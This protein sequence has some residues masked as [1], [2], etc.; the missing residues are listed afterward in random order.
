MKI[1]FHQ[2]VS[3][4]KKIAFVPKHRFFSNFCSRHEGTVLTSLSYCSSKSSK[5]FFAW[6]PINY[7]FVVL[8]SLSKKFRQKAE[9]VSFNIPE[10]PKNTILLK[11]FL[12]VLFL[13][14]T[15]TFWEFCWKTLVKSQHFLAQCPKEMNRK[16]FCNIFLSEWS[17]RHVKCIFENLLE[18][19]RQKP[20][21]V[22]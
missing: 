10:V 6:N 15:N 16:I 11:N 2:N 21:K 17:S 19:N 22:C 20:K 9:V 12:N 3:K 14:L 7:E 18:K 4:I 5:Y 1:S 8:R 13:T